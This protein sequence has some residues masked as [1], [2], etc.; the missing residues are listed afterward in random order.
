[1]LSTYSNQMVRLNVD[2]SVDPHFTRLV[3]AGGSLDSS[4][5]VSRL[6]LQADGKILVGGSFA[7]IGGV[8]RQNLARLN[9]DGTLDMN[10]APAAPVIGTASELATLPAAMASPG[11]IALQVDGKILVGGSFTNVQAIGRNA[12]VRFNADGTLDTSFSPQLDSGSEVFTL[13]PQAD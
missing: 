13:L 2:G 10:F 11:P 1:P 6:L 3:V 7:N 12:L 5:F 8:A 9:S 4:P